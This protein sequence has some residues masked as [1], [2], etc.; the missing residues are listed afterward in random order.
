MRLFTS[1]IIVRQIYFLTRFKVP[2]HPN[3]VF[4]VF[5]MFLELIYENHGVFFH[6]TL[7]RD[8]YSQKWPKTGL[9][10]NSRI[11]EYA[12]MPRLLGQPLMNMQMCHVPDIC[13]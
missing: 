11:N 9:I 3:H 4:L 2:L 8:F 6:S 10:Y 7:L 12:T 13:I 1:D 5:N